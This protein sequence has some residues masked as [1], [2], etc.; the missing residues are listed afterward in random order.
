MTLEPFKVRIDMPPMPFKR[1]VHYKNHVY[2][3]EDYKK[4]KAGIAQFVHKEMGLRG[5]F[6][7]EVAIEISF[8]R[9]LPR[10]ATSKQWGDLDNLVKGILDALTGVVYEDDSQIVEL[11]A[12]KRYGEPHIEIEVVDAH[13]SIPF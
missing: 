12:Y 5:L 7:D 2:S 4:Y 9:M 6:L 10:R 11:H 13:N 1:V 8:Y 3:P